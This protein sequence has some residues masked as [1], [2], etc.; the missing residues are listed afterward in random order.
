MYP[1][2]MLKVAYH[3]DNVGLH[4][5]SDEA[6]SLSSLFAKFADYSVEEDE[7]DRQKAESLVSTVSPEATAKMISHARGINFHPDNLSQVSI[8]PVALLGLFN[9]FAKDQGYESFE[10]LQAKANV[11]DI[12]KQL[13]VDKDPAVEQARQQGEA[14]LYQIAL[15]MMQ[16]DGPSRDARLRHPKDQS[17]MV[18]GTPRKF[19]IQALL[20]YYSGTPT[21]EILLK[22]RRGNKEIIEGLKRSLELTEKLSSLLSKKVVIASKQCDDLQQAH[23]LLCKLFA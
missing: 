8:D 18:P 14:L 17:P 1:D 9:K 3:L 19:V 15:R 13:S 23:A 11:D 22:A 7:A 2:I 5:L 4:H 10:A 21:E 12:I 20:D 6:H 16:E